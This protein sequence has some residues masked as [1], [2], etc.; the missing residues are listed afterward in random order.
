MVDSC[1]GLRYAVNKLTV[2]DISE[3]VVVEMVYSDAEVGLRRSAPVAVKIEAVPYPDATSEGR[4]FPSCVLDAVFPGGQREVIGSH[5]QVCAEKEATDAVVE[6]D[7]RFRA[8][9]ECPEFPGHFSVVP[10]GIMER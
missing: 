7:P 1:P 5:L 10:G 3:A 4:M 9:N 8:E 2:S 6:P